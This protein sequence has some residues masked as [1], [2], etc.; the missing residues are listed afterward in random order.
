MLIMGVDGEM[1]LNFKIVGDGGWGMVHIGQCNVWLILDFTC[2]EIA[3]GP[4]FSLLFF[5]IVHIM[6]SIVFPVFII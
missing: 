6:R 3:C 5:I 4:F 2:P 1:C